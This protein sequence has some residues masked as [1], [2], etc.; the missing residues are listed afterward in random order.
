MKS[1]NRTLA[2]FR[3]ELITQSEQLTYQAY[4]TAFLDDSLFE[5]IFILEHFFPL[6]RTFPSVYERIQSVRYEKG[7]LNLTLTP[8][9]EVLLTGLWDLKDMR[10]SRQNHSKN[11]LIGENAVT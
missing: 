5:G 7:K 8:F 6:K 11:K 2:Y 4:V 3:V 9:S 10:D 1:G